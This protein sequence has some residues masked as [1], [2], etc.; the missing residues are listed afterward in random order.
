M[1][2]LGIMAKLLDFCHDKREYKLQ[3]CNYVPFWSN[4][5]GNGMESLILLATS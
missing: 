3:S 2:R 4:S 1:I 5:L